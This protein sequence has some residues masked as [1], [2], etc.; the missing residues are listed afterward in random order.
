MTGEV[1]VCVFVR[2]TSKHLLKMTTM[3]C[4]HRLYDSSRMAVLIIDV[5]RVLYICVRRLL[6]NQVIFI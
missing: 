5:Q 4:F 3:C 2:V 1:R 6:H